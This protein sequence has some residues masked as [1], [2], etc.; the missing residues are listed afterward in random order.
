M[1][2]I[3]EYEGTQYHGFQFQINASSIQEKLEEAINRFTGEKIRIKGAGRTDAGVHAKGQVVAFDTANVSLPETFV[4]AIN[5]YL[6]DDIAVKAAYHADS[7]FDPRRMALSRR[8]RYTIE[9]GPVPSPLLRRTTYRIG[10]RL[11]VRRMQRAAAWF[12]GRHDFAPFAASMDTLN[13]STVRE[14]NDSRVRREGSTILF[15]IEGNAFLTHQV[16]RM[17]GSLV[18]VGRGRLRPAE[19]K[20]MIEGEGDAVAAHALPPHGLCLLNVTYADFPPEIGDSYG[21]TS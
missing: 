1:A 13:T 10:G 15:E 16:R 20:A 14:I 21:N 4:R 17:A 8:Y 2:L 19:L 5:H 9:C 3:I 6:P 18:D 11:N 12:V 7:D